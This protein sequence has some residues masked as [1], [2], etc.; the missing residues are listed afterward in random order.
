MR[1]KIS[2]TKV[3]SEDGYS[4]ALLCKLSGNGAAE[5]GANADNGGDALGGGGA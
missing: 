5:I 2:L 3:P 1:R 4:V